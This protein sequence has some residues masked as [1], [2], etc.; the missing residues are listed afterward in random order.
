MQ[1]EKPLLRIATITLFLLSSCFFAATSVIAKEK[2]GNSGKEAADQDKLFDPEHIVQVDIKI[3]PDKWEQLCKQSRDFFASLRVDSSPESPFTYVKADVTVNGLKIKNVG[4]RKKG[5][6]GS[7]DSDRPSLKIRF[8]KYV[9]QEPFG[10]LSRLTLNNNKQDESNLSQYLAYRLFSEMGVVSPRCNFAKVTVN[11]EY[12]GIYSNVES[13][14]PAMLE[15]GFGD[16]GGVLAEGTVTDLLPSMTQRFEY[17]KKH[18]SPSTIEK[19][20]AVLAKPNLD[21]EELS[22]LLNIDSFIRYWATESMTGFW[23]GYTHNQNNFFIYDNPTDS[24]LYFIPWGVDSAYTYYIPSIIDPIKHP[25]FHSNSVLANRLYHHPKMRDQYRKT[26]QGM[27]AEQWNE[28]EILT[29]ISRVESMLSNEVLNPRTFSKGVNRVRSFVE[30]R[31]RV[32]EN[33]LEKWPIRID[34]GPRVPGLVAKYGDLAGDF[35]TIWSKDTPSSPDNQGKVD[36]K[37]RLAD[38]DVVFHN[39]GVT[40]KLSNHSNDQA[41]D[42]ILTPTIIFTGVR[43]SDDMTLTLVAKVHPKDFHPSKEAVPVNGVLIEGSMLSFFTMLALNPGAIK[44]ITGTVQ[45]NEAS[46]EDRKPVAGKADLHVI[47]F[48]PKKQ[49][50]V[51]WRAD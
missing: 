1:P 9:D 51:S 41:R 21:L 8:N 24:K 46:M 25:L 19:L 4:I 47:G 15:R 45:L 5:F 34:F 10:V 48:A 39:I 23:D 32:L 26:I 43:E 27:L 20:T 31:R 38:E 12:L 42:G 14:K 11:G 49:A 13:V 35:S 30:G 22:S 29:E 36:V 7:L 6:L 16:G 18:D 37:M 33:Q 28:T 44:I 2:E 3:D 40:T 50:K 17:K